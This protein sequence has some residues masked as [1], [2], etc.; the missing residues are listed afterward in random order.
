[1]GIGEELLAFKICIKQPQLFIIV[2]YQELLKRKTTNNLKTA[3]PIQL[4]RFMKDLILCLVSQNL[5]ISI[6]RK[7]STQ[8]SGKL[9]ICQNRIKHVI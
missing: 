6:A 9:L 1:M 4:D 3:N 8:A 7:L 5:L 2:R